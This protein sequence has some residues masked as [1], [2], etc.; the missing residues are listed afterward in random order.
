L[1][2]YLTKV[3][4]STLAAA[5]AQ[6]RYQLNNEGISFTVAANHLNSETSQTTDYQLARKISFVGTAGGRGS[7]RGGG[8]GYQG[9]GV[10]ADIKDVEEATSST[11][12][13]TLRQNRRNSHRKNATRKG[14]RVVLSKSCPN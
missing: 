2:N 13:T 5:V 4:C 1:T 6:L 10:V 8:R 9:R 14:S 11:P 3:Q 12:P 7:G